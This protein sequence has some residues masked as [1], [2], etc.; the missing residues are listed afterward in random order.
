M[1]CGCFNRLSSVKGGSFLVAD[2]HSNQVTHFSMAFSE[3]W[4]K[5]PSPRVSEAGIQVGSRRD[6]RIR[7][8]GGTS[9][10]ES[11]SRGDSMR[12]KPISARTSRN[13]STRTIFSK[14]FVKS[15]GGSTA[16]SLKNLLSF[17]EFG[18]AK[19]SHSGD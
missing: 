13:F 6:S 8:S 7:R 4:K 11:K 5:T 18:L 12:V 15:S 17:D 1:K 10:G 14:N 9:S 2:E 16:R 19:T 3:N